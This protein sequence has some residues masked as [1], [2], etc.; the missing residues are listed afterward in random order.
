MLKKIEQE[1]VSP[2]QQIQLEARPF[3]EIQKEGETFGGRDE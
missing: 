3:L 2:N 1:Q